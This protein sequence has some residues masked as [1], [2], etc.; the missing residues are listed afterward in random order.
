MNFTITPIECIDGN[1]GAKVKV[2]KI[3][4]THLNGPSLGSHCASSRQQHG[5][6]LKVFLTLL[7]IASFFCPY[8]HRLMVE[9]LTM[10][11]GP[12]STD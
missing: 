3:Y 9:L 7:I 2:K 1:Y 8:M 5:P 11:G 4:K 12:A 6:R 10:E